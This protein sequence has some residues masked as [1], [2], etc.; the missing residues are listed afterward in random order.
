[1]YVLRRRLAVREIVGYSI[2]VGGILLSFWLAASRRAEEPMEGDPFIPLLAV[3]IG[4]GLV[5]YAVVS[6]ALRKAGPDPNATSVP[7]STPRPRIWWQLRVGIAALGIV[8]GGLGALA[9]VAILVLGILSTPTATTEGPGITIVMGLLVLVVALP[10][11]GIGWLL[12]P[13]RHST[14]QPP[15]SFT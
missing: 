11:F 5:V 7:G 13:R 8:F 2:L 14:V 4:G 1:M 15:E 10:L 3:W 12:R 6:R 9:G